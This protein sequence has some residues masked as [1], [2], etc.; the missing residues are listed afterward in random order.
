MPEEVGDVLAGSKAL[1]GGPDSVFDEI[2]KRG[3]E[4]RSADVGKDDITKEG[5]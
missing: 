5:G 2:G 4:V 3:E 1:F